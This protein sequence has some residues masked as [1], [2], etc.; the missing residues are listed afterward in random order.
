[1]PGSCNDLNILDNSPL[2]DDVFAGRFPPPLTYRIGQKERRRPH[3]LADGIYPSWSIFVQSYKNPSTEEQRH[4]EMKQESCRKDVERAFG[5][6]QAK[7]QVV[8]RPSRLWKDSVM[9]VIMH[10][11]IILH[12]MACEYREKNK[13]SDRA[14][15]DNLTEIG[16]TSTAEALLHGEGGISL[17]LESTPPGSIINRALGTI[18][19]II[20]AEEHRD[21]RQDLVSYLWNRR[22]V[23]SV[24]TFT[25]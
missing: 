1:M 11:C 10:C 8:A 21:L 20:D 6:L 7:F 22:G 17:E 5:V 9:A 16:S 15:R 13:G 2:I 3:Y 12:N 24:E 4:F 25:E 14:V 19:E 18:R 23:A